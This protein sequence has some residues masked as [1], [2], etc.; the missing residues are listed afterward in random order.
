[1]APVEQRRDLLARPHVIADASGHQP[2]DEDEPIMEAPPPER[3]HIDPN[4]RG[5]VGVHAQPDFAFRWPLP[6][7]VVVQVEVKGG[8][9]TQRGVDM[10][11]R[12]LDLVRETVP[13]DGA[14]P[15][16]PTAPQPPSERSPVDAQ[17]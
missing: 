5:R 7:G 12:Y 3:D 13:E 8:P 2:D 9:L 16:P 4:F 11:S 14:T 1:L 15:S 10:L 6:D 17:D